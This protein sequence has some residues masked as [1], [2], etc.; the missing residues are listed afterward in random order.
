MSQILELLK[1]RRVWAGLVGL[2]SFALTALHYELQIDVPLLTDLLTS[3]GGAL[4]TSITAG[5]ALWSYFKPKSHILPL[6]NDNLK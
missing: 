2:F 5:L 3:F 1:Q 4:A 6:G